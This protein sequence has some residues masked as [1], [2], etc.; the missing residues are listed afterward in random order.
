LIQHPVEAIK[1]KWH[2]QV[3]VIVH[4]AI[5]VCSI[6]YAENV[7]KEPNTYLTTKYASVNAHK[8]KFGLI[9]LKVVYVPGEHIQSMENV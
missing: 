1:I 9:L 4:L 8:I 2:I 6:R 5:I 3:V 7:L